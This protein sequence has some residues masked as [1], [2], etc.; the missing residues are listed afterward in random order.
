MFC[1]CTRADLASWKRFKQ[2]S[3]ESSGLLA[4]LK[5]LFGKGIQVLT[6]PHW[7]LC[8][9]CGRSAPRWLEETVS[10]LANLTKVWERFALDMA[11][12]FMSDSKLLVYTPAKC[13]GAQ[14]WTFRSGRDQA[15]RRLNG[16][17][18]LGIGSSKGCETSGRK[19]AHYRLSPTS[20]L[21]LSL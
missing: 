8:I 12:R 20:D 3:R 17:Q 15:Y 7:A 4:T 18:L 11:S 5:D 16:H 10:P 6:L 19:H 21:T 9:L 14:T 13:F 1:I 2:S